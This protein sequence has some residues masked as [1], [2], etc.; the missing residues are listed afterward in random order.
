M[1][2]MDSV[3]VGRLKPDEWLGRRVS[4]TIDRPIGS[5]HPRA[6]FEYKCNY[7]FVPGL[8]APDGEE[9]DAYVLGPTV[10]LAEY[11][12]VVVAVVLRRD[13]VED[14]LVVGEGCS[15]W[16]AEAVGRAVAFQEQFFDA[17]IVTATA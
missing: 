4:V 10:P 2:L 13:D 14:K 8:I 15:L 11:V 5:T 12:G 7:G 9:L 6:G 1:R 16:T 3:D 17:R